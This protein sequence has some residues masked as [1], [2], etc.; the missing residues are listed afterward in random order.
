MPGAPTNRRLPSYPAT[1]SHPSSLATSYLT[2]VAGDKGDQ[3]PLAF[4]ERKDRAIVDRA[5]GKTGRH[6]ASALIDPHG[7]PR[8][9]GT[10]LFATRQ[11]GKAHRCQRGRV[12]TVAPRCT[13]MFARRRARDESNVSAVG[14]LGRDARRRCPCRGRRRRGRGIS[15]QSQIPQLAVSGIELPAAAKPLQAVIASKRVLDFLSTT[16]K[17]DAVSRAAIARCTCARNEKKSGRA[18][19]SSTGS[20]S[21]GAAASAVAP[22]AQR[23]R[24]G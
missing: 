24:K 6:V 18:L 9:I 19:A 23:Q 12:C 15:A 22:A 20:S 4:A 7:R 11:D 3:P 1:Q 8:R 16:A 14:Q 5:P 17:R 10:L 13:R 2:S 21:D